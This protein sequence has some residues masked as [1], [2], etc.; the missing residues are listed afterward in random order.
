MKELDGEAIGTPT[1]SKSSKKAPSLVLQRLDKSEQ[2]TLTQC[3][4]QFSFRVPS[5]LKA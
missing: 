4:D 3:L 1:S 2:E 5:T